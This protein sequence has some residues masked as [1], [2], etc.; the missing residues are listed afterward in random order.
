MAIASYN[1]F[2][3]IKEAVDS[4]LTQT[5]ENIEIIISNDGSSD[6]KEDEI[7]SY[8]EKNK[9]SNITNVVV[10]NFSNNQGTVK[11]VNYLC[12]TAKGEYIMIMAAD[13]ALYDDNVIK[14][15]VDSFSNDN[16][17]RY[18][19]CGKIA[20]C[21]SQLDDVRSYIPSDEEI[22]VLKE[23]NSEI[24]FSKLAKGAFVPT[25]SCCYKREVF[26]QLGYNDE[27]NFIIEDY[28]FHIKM[29]L[30][31]YRFG[32]ID[33][34]VGAR[35]RDG[36]IS[37]GNTRVKS[38]SYRRY[39]YD[40]IQIIRDDILPNI[41]KVLPEDKKVFLKKW[42][43]LKQAYYLDFIEGEDKS[44][45]IREYDR[46]FC[47]EIIPIYKKKM[48]FLKITR[49]LSAVA[50][51]TNLVYN[52]IA[53]ILALIGIW[54]VQ[55]VNNCCISLLPEYIYGGLE[56][57]LYMFIILTLWFTAIYFSLRI[58]LRVMYDALTKIL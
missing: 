22:S 42:D 23:G 54:G 37:H 25:T 14:T 44:Y 35:H 49:R 11:N 17:D 16:A 8:I 51:T 43:Y 36:G 46:A 56:R 48:K 53:L 20:M 47:E 3:Y 21:G 9:R 7:V 39:R 55:I 45:E 50:Q 24:I 18:C 26:Q 40:E 29:A 58:L 52:G 15:F 30:N 5:Y 6:F 41:E 13:D 2:E 31:G 28:S 34:F 4:I 12:K 33:N 57:T 32:W 38:E 27:K 10:N 1:N 19:I